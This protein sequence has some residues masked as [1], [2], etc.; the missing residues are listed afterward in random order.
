[1]YYVIKI[2]A[3]FY[4][5]PPCHQLSTLERTP[6]PADDVMCERSLTFKIME[7]TLLVRVVFF[8][9]AFRIVDAMGG[10]KGVLCE[11]YTV[12]AF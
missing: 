5:P 9:H 3:D 11:I 4:P 6:P 8:V 7:V 10:I 2:C 12:H 1:M